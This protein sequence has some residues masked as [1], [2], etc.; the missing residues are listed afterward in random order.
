MFVKLFKA[1]LCQEQE[2]HICFSFVCKVKKGQAI[3]FSSSEL[4]QSSTVEIGD[5]CCKMTQLGQGVILNLD[6]LSLSE[7]LK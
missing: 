3:F 6:Y 5:N 7:K 2:D 4:V 1:W